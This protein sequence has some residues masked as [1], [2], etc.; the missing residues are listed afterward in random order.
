MPMKKLPILPR[1]LH[2]SAKSPYI[3]F[4]WRDRQRVQHQKSTR[5]TDPV[6]ALRFKIEFLEQQEKWPD[7]D[8]LPNSRSLSRMP[9]SE[10]SERYFVWKA[11]TNSEDTIRREKRMFRNVVR[12]FGASLRVRVIHLAMIREY[13]QM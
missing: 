11:V 10:I 8:V 5:M 3:C 6:E 12:F 2:R 9:L 1:G 13:Q 4:S 7:D